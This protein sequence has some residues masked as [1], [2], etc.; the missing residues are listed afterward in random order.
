[1]KV[2]QYIYNITLWLALILLATSA[3]ASEQFEPRPIAKSERCPVCGMYPANYPQWHSQI[4]FKD[5]QHSSFDSPIEMFRFVHNPSRY[6]KRHDAEAIGKIYVTDFEQGGWVDARLAYYVTG[7]SAK[8]PMGDDLPAF[9]SKDK[10]A[11]FVKKF[12]GE[13]LTFQ[14]V[15]PA[16]INGGHN[17]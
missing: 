8:G 5:G 13:V 12:G 4:V 14:Q 2:K 6:D 16:L 15:T 1:M 17:H 10:A 11:G 7:S 9:A 3:Q